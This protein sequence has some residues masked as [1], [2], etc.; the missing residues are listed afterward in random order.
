MGKTA[1]S[2]ETQS[3]VDSA[4]TSAAKSHHE[5]RMS[6]TIL[7][8]VIPISKKMQQILTDYVIRAHFIEIFCFI[9]KFV[10]LSIFSSYICFTVHFP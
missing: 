3:E 6:G 8:S 9:V 10:A 4:I 2:I 7:C 1:A 5:K